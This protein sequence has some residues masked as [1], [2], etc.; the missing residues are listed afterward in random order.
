MG[1][2]L[3]W[4]LYVAVQAQKYRRLGKEYSLGLLFLVASYLL[5]RAITKSRSPKQTFALAFFALLLLATDLRVHNSGTEFNSY[6]RTEAQRITDTFSDKSA[7]V[8]FLRNGLQSD[9]QN[10]PYRSEIIAAEAFLANGSMPIGVHATQ[11]YNPMRYVL[12]DRATGARAFF[13]VPRPFTPL[14]PSYN[15]PLFDLLAV[16]YVAAVAELSQIDPKVD[17]SRFKL[18]FDQGLKVWE[19]QDVLPRVLTA[20]AFR[21]DSNVEGA[22]EGSGMPQLDYRSVAILTHLPESLARLAGKEQT[23]TLLPGQG[24]ASARITKYRNSEVVVAARS[25]RDVIVIL[26]DIYYPYWRVYVD[27]RAAELLQANYIF[28]GV[29]VSP[30]D[31]EIVFRFEPFSWGSVKETIVRLVR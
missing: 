8:Q 19:N 20:T 18:V 12:Y 6:P 15:S 26:N 23:V 4:G 21:V 5:L 10:G 3:A 9:R 17:R 29:H 24:D 2:L 7:F 14:M 11:G 30:G 22:L 31:H 16:K 1:A 13:S 28:R 25:S 27:G